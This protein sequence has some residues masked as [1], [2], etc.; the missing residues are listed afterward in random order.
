MLNNLIR[1]LHEFEKYLRRNERTMRKY[2]CKTWSLKIEKFISYSSWTFF[3]YPLYRPC[4]LQYTHLRWCAPRWIE[5]KFLSRVRAL[6]TACSSPSAP[7][8]RRATLIYFDLASRPQRDSIFYLV[9][10]FARSRTT[11]VSPFRPFVLFR[12]PLH[13]CTLSPI[14]ILAPSSFSICDLFASS[15]RFIVVIRGAKS[16]PSG[17]ARVPRKKKFAGK[18]APDIP[19]RCEGEARKANLTDDSVMSSGPLYRRLRAR[20]NYTALIKAWWIFLHSPNPIV[21]PGAPRYRVT[22]HHDLRISRLFRSQDTRRLLTHYEW[23]IALEEI[24]AHCSSWF[25]PLRLAGSYTSA[26]LILLLIPTQ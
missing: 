21:D 15:S 25:V 9:R 17:R 5:G 26:K 18:K 14:T 16:L 2:S 19:L 11:R 7:I 24:L 13:S 6:R 4:V 23:H 3:I 20:R 22:I 1:R 12:R 10:V 8:S